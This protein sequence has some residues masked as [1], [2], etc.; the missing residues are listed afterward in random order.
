MPQNIK[1]KTKKKFNLKSSEGNKSGNSR[2]QQ[3][4]N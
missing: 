4:A 3:P 1:W 2:K